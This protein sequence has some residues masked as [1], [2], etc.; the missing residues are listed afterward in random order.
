MAVN[1]GMQFLYPSFSI[2]RSSR[3]E[4]RFKPL[5]NRFKPNIHNVI[6]IADHARPGSPAR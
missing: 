6:H 3:R 2:H 5:P 4:S 1:P